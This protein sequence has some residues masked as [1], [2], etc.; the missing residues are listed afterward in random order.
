[1]G[2]K[3]TAPA[4]ALAWFG[5]LVSRIHSKG[6]VHLEGTG[7][8]L[9]LRSLRPLGISETTVPPGG[10]AVLPK[11]STLCRRAWASLSGEVCCHHFT[12][13]AQ[14]RW[15]SCP[16]SHSQ[17]EIGPELKLGSAWL[18]SHHCPPCQRLLKAPTAPGL[19]EHPT[20][21]TS[22]K[23]RD[24][25]LP[26]GKDTVHLDG[27]E[28]GRGF[29]GPPPS[30]PHPHHCAGACWVRGYGCQLQRWGPSL[31]QPLLGLKEACPLR[32]A[33]QCLSPPLLPPRPLLVTDPG[34][35]PWKKLGA[36]C[37][38]PPCPA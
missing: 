9:V 6:R 15:L 21:P 29:L 11:E 12:D 13:E 20:S 3:P 2:V 37:V 5:Q 27:G 23:G 22:Q 19:G 17:P 16:E 33:P 10:H 34:Q 4:P 24:V 31:P 25:D 1:M 7:P 35:Q 28:R 36:P 14:T 30:H 26:G 32:T 8:L 38:Q 18:P